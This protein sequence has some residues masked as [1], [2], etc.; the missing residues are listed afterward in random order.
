ML[1]A[2]LLKSFMVK[3]PFLVSKDDQQVVEW[4]VG[5]CVWDGC[6]QKQI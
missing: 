5:D 4:L 3:A 6:C 2:D 1:H